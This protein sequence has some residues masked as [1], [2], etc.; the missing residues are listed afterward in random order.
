[1]RPPLPAT[2]RDLGHEHG[3]FDIVGDVHGC[4]DELAALLEALGHRAGGPHPEGRRLVFLGDLVDRGPKI[5]EVLDRVMA[6]VAAGRALCVLGN[7]EAKLL[8]KLGGREV[9]VG[10]GL[11]ATLRQFEARSPAWVEGVRRFLDGLVGH[12]VLAG[13][14][15]VVAHAGM[16]AALQGQDSRA[17]RA[18]ALYGE[19]TGELDEHGLPVRLPWAD[20][21]DGEALVV[22]G[23]TP[24]REA[25]LHNNTVCVDTG[26]VFGGALTALRWPELELASVPAARVYVEPPRPLR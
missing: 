11:A 4:D 8:R 1:M 5:P 9:R 14:R 16:K 23:H 22:Y 10:G 17:A 18:F 20:D 21:Y 7:H 25:R 6:L 24:V 19:T 12:H 2:P 15:L 13:G 26:C 3:P